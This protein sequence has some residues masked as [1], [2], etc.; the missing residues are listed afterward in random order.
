MTRNGLTRIVAS[1]VFSSSLLLSSLELSDTTI[2]E[3]SLVVPVQSSH[4]WG[5]RMA[6]K[7]ER[8]KV[9]LLVDSTS[10]SLLEELIK[11]RFWWNQ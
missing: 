1:L 2:Y 8:F 3:P 10:V 5:E 7:V 4:P 11:S 6:D 9:S